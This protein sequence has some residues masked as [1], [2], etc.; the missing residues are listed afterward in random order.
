MAFNN[1]EIQPMSYFRLEEHSNVILA[2]VFVMII[3][4][5][6]LLPAVV[7]L[8]IAQSWLRTPLQATFFSLNLFGVLLGVTYNRQT[9]NL[10]ENEKHGLLGWVSTFLAAV[11]LAC[12]LVLSYLRLKRRI[13]AEDPIYSPSSDVSQS[14]LLSDELA[15]SSFE[16]R[17]IG[18]SDEDMDAAN[19]ICKA[20]DLSPRTK[21]SLRSSQSIKSLLVVTVAINDWLILL[22]GFSCVTTGAAVYGGMFQGHNIFTGLAHFIKGGIFV[23]CGLLTFGRWLGSFAKL[24]WAWN[25][26]PHN[27]STRL[28]LSSVPSAEFVECLL[29]CL[30]GASNIWLEHLNNLGGDWSTADIQHVSITVKFFGGGLLGM[31]IES[32]IVPKVTTTPRPKSD[33][34]E[35]P[36]NPMPAIVIYLLGSIMGEHHQAS[37]VIAMLHKRW[38]ELFMGA[39]IARIATYCILYLKPPSDDSPQRP[40]TEIVTSLCLVSGGIVLMISNKDTGKMLEGSSIDAIIVFNIAVGT[41]AILMAWTAVCLAIK[42]AAKRRGS[43][44]C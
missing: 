18:P 29:I 24:G 33:R 1:T 4:W 2:H 42:D 38:G 17:D 34:Y 3:T 39:A 5:V 14:P 21:Y 26:K 11:W 40:F 9:P 44:V 35:L 19:S 37:T 13:Q 10:Y 32:R 22:L 27:K 43:R 36:M 15:G 8:S 16:Y 6:F 31:L 7:M 28:W 25:K 30:Y 12:G 41:T 23:F 20:R